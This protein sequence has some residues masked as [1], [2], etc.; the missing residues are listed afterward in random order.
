MDEIKR[1]FRDSPITSFTNYDVNGVRAVLSQLEMGNFRQPGLMADAMTRDDRIGGVLRTRALGLLGLQVDF[2]HD[3]GDGRRNAS[4]IKAVQDRWGVMF[5]QDAQAE[6]LSYA[7]L[8]GV[9]IAELIWDTS[10][11]GRWTPTIKVWHPTFI[12]WR[13]DTQSFWIST[14]DGQVEVKSGEGKWAVLQMG[15]Q[16][17]WMSGLMR[18]LA[19]PWMIRQY[20]YRDWARYSEVHGLPIRVGMVPSGGDPADRARFIGQVQNLASQSVVLLPQGTSKD[21]PGFDLKLLEAAALSWQGFEKLIERTETSIGVAVLGQNLTTEIRGGSFAAASVHDRIRQDI[22]EA[23]ANML[24]QA[25]LEGILKPWALFNYGS[26]DLA[27]IPDYK[28]DPPTDTK[29]KA[30]SLS[31]IG[32]VIGKFQDAGIQLDLEQL[33][34]NFD[35][36]IAEGAELNLPPEPVRVPEAPDSTAGGNGTVNKDP[37]PQLNTITLASGAKLPASSPFVQGQLYADALVDSGAARASPQ[38]QLSEVLKVIEAAEDYDSLRKAL[39]KLYK[40]LSADEFAGVLE[41][42]LILADLAGRYAAG[43]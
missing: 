42:S 8:L 11:P 12:Q 43:G 35:I 9:S 30:D 5:P 17:P 22:L 32:D 25:E 29:V 2:E 18:S 34:V 31:T 4:V 7:Y 6:W 37:Q 36:P 19:I 23:D 27:P 21:E 3:K 14:L 16:R 24:Q 1:N 26:T 28:T 41:K 33:A 40:G 10:T 20:A 38:I 13:W 15:R 39:L